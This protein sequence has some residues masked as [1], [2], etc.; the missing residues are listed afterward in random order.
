MKNLEHEHD[1]VFGDSFARYDRKAMNPL[2]E[3]L[4]IRFKVNGVPCNLFSGKRCLDAGCGGG[5][6]SLFMSKY[7]AHRVDSLDVSQKN[8]ETT[9]LNAERFGFMNNIVPYNGTIERL[10]YDDESFDVVWCYGVVHHTAHPD[11]C[12][13]E[14]SRVLKIGG[15]LIMF[16]YGTG[17]ILWYAVHRARAFTRN[18]DVDE[19][20]AALDLCGT[21]IN[22]HTSIMDN[23]K[24]PYLRVYD[25]DHVRARL[26]EYGLDGSD[27][28]PFGMHWD[29]NHR[30]NRFPQDADWMGGGDLRFL[31]I[32]RRKLVGGGASRH[33]LDK[34]EVAPDPRYDERLIQVFRPLFNELDD[35]SA[36]NQIAGLC[37][38][39]NVFI[40]LAEFLRADCPFEHLRFSEY[41]KDLNRTLQVA[42]GRN[43]AA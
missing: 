42:I 34:E 38:H 8:V 43:M 7:G 14:L 27:P 39:R 1:R 17:G 23:W 29:T 5:P 24:V 25:W 11:K 30:R 36:Q 26:L 6:A 28:L 35:I 3:N 22:M 19:C 12:L 16:L 4:E 41:L 40:Q 31:A 37:A 15:T 10:P 13:A 21:E 33:S 9:R 20:R 2:I 18:I 32:K